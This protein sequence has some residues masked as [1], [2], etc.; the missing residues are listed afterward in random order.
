[1]W[2]VTGSLTALDLRRCHNPPPLKPLVLAE[3]LKA[4]DRCLKEG[5]RDNL[6]RMLDPS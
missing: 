2:I 5:G 6:D 3:D 4:Q 1:M